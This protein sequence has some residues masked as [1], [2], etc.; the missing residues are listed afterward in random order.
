MD[1]R[2]EILVQ[3]GLVGGDQ[4]AALRP[5]PGEG[6]L[7]ALLRT[8]FVAEPAYLAAMAARTGWPVYDFAAP[9]DFASRV[10][11]PELMRQ[12]RAIPVGEDGGG[13]LVAVADPFHAACLDDLQFLLGRPVRFA[14]ASPRLISIVLAGLETESAPPPPPPTPPPPALDP[15]LEPSDEDVGPAIRLVREFLDSGS[16]RGASELVLEPGEDA[17]RVRIRRLSTG[18]WVEVASHPRALYRA[19]VARLKILANV[20]IAERRVPQRGVVRLAE[21][22]HPAVEVLVS[23]LPVGREEEVCLHFLPPRSRPPGVDELGL[24]AAAREGCEAW[25]AGRAGLFLSVGPALSGRSTTLL[26]LAARLARAPGKLVAIGHGVHPSI[27]RGCQIA[28]DPSVGLT[29]PSALA[30]ALRHR[31]TAVL[32]DAPLDREAAER[33][34]LAAEGVHVLA[35]LPVPSPGAAVDRLLDMGLEPWP[36]SGSLRAVVSQRLVRLLCLACRQAAPGEPYPFRAKG[37][38]A[39]GHTGYSGRRAVFDALFLDDA[40]RRSIVSRGRFPDPAADRSPLREAALALAREGLTT[41]E[42]ALRTTN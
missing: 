33:L 26:A 14:V 18:D 27:P 31:P 2:L 23:T 16:T 28:I 41:P 17:F 8:G 34:A 11:A 39:C 3:D 37:C 15:E 21:G 7:E 20:D 36:V 40:L 5:A 12:Y 38:P 22:D 10:L 1:R 24:P 29:G 6:P 35:S 19:V 4:L 30:A 25:I 9:P 42:E 32:Y 13:I